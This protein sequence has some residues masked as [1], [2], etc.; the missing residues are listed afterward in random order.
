M[1]A[2]LEG[3]DSDYEGVQQAKLRLE[4]MNSEVS[5]D[6]SIRSN[7][8]RMMDSDVSIRFKKK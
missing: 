6:S 3:R 2:L 7:A 1:P 8:L 5:A 4:Q